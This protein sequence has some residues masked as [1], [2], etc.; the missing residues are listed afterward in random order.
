MKRLAT[1]IGMISLTL[2]AYAAVGGLDDEPDEDM[3]VAQFLFRRELSELSFFVSPK[4]AMKTM[5]TPAA[6][7]G[8]MQKNL[9]LLYQLTS[10]TEMYETGVNKG[11]YKLSAKFGK[12]VP[13]WSA[14]FEKD[15]E[16]ALRF[17]QNN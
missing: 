9:D 5:A 3:L 7:V 15:L 4:D 14:A 1:E 6:T 13:F 11:R 12:M 17:Q 2:L 16:A 10:P 8:I